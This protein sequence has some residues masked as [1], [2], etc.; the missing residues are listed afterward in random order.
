VNGPAQGRGAP[1][2]LIIKLGALGDFVQA[3]GPCAAIRTHHADARITLMTTAPFAEFARTCPYF[4]E[5][6]TDARPRAWN[7]GGWLALRRRL[8][9]AR[10]ER[11]YDL[12]TSD[13]TAAYYLMLGPGR[14]PE[15]SGTAPGCSHPDD[16]PE[17]TRI[18][19]IERQREQ[20]RR[21]GIATVPLPDLGWVEA[22]VR[23]FGLPE[24]AVLLVPGGAAHRPDKRWPAAAYAELARRLLVGNFTP[25][26]IGAA[27]EAATLA[28][29][30]AAAPGTIDMCGRTSVADIVGLARDAAA[31][32]GNDTGPMHLITAA[33]CPGVVLFSHASDPAR[34]AQRGPAGGPEPAILRRADLGALTVEEVEAVL[35]PR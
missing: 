25:A 16:N 11:V 15:W 26:L 3:L 23:R 29:I 19:T 31:A 33:G 1:R 18:H 30:A 6:W 28:E 21:A 8:R 2:I 13:R 10:F 35:A 9:G 17:R 27:A 24:R 20:L 5:V 14:R 32:V 4:D 12:Q 7:F 34:C 22:D